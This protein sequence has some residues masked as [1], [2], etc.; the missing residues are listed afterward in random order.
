ML[1]EVFRSLWTSLLPSQGSLSENIKVVPEV[2]PHVSDGLAYHRAGDVAKAEAAYRKALRRNSRDVNALHL[3]SI[4]AYRRGDF[5]ETEKLVRS[6][7]A[8]Q[9]GSHVILNTL[10]SVLASTGRHAEAESALIE[11]LNENP[12]ALNARE[13][14]LFLLNIIPDVSRERLLAEHREWGM[15]NA[16][17]S[18]NRE[19]WNTT[20]S[21]Q[22]LS[23]KSRRM[24]I[25]YVSA[26][27]CSHPVGR[28]VSGIIRLHDRSRFEVFCYDNG[29]ENDA[30]NAALRANAEHWVEAGTWEDKALAAR[31]EKD[32]IQVLVD[33][34]GHTRRHRLH[35]FA[36]KPSPV[37]ATWL[38]YLNTTG[39]SALDWRLTDRR[40]DPPPVAQ[41]WHV[42]RLWYLPDCQWVWEAPPFA[43]PLASQP[44]CIEAGHVTFGSFNTFRKINDKVIE[45]WSK[46][47]RRLP[48]TR[49]RVYGAPWGKA[50][51]R[52]YDLF[53]VHGIHSSRVDLF[54]SIE[55]SRY[56]RAYGDI[57]ISLDPFPY[58][59]GATTC[60]SLWMGVPVVTL[61][62]R[63]GFSRSGASILGA[64]NLDELIAA[65]EAE[66]IDIA[67]RLAVDENSLVEMRKS[68]RHK[69]LSSP[70]SD[71]SRF[72][73]NLERAYMGMWKDWE[74]RNLQSNVEIV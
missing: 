38:G 32:E 6:A 56:L 30:I 66:Y 16:S 43:V 46:I 14:L 55:Y 5:D 25:G 71:S 57:D 64:M 70:L 4:A 15:R 22:R 2:D 35:V 51:D 48:G 61:A 74:F 37:Q 34:S 28:I 9:P 23:S 68:L 50:V 8:F 52:V 10:A 36:L 45:T 54:A 49:L 60:E 41:Q 42:E 20:D 69:L 59:G 47:L 21:R 31:I 73:E 40:A 26:D 19:S 33:L 18:L 44:P 7:L 65:T 67:C 27:F 58:N 13:N 11:A 39:I 1:L 29:S 62:G 72:T 12:N 24:R 63:G 53:E 17:P 3:L